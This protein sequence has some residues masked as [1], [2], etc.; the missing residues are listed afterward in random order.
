MKVNNIHEVLTLVLPT[1]EPT[2]FYTYFLKSLHNMKSVA[3]ITTVA[4]NFQE[5]WTEEEISDAVSKIRDLGFEC[6][7]S[8][9]KYKIEGK[10]RVPFNRIRD[11]AS[12]LVPNS[13]IFALT[14]DDFEYKGP[15]GS[16]NK[17]AGDQYLD[18]VHYM[19]THERCGIISMVGTL[20]RKVPRNHIGPCSLHNIYITNKGFLLKSLNAIGG[21]GY[22]LPVGCLDLVGSDEERVSTGARMA[23]GYYPAKL[24]FA[25]TGHYENHGKSV[26]SGETMYGWNEEDILNENN[27]KFIK[28]NYNPKFRKREHGG[29]Q[30]CST[31]KYLAE[32]GLDIHSQDVIDELTTDYTNSVPSEILNEIIELVTM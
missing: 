28:D 30:P 15:S 26:V 20:Y 17:T 29:D 16:I 27:T 7:W 32:G 31:D 25:R 21:E 13:L 11:D 18:A 9:N 23:L 4:I 10:G 12:K 5:P 24:P 2:T 6:K 1:N 22:T 14:D 8:F 19:L 3:P